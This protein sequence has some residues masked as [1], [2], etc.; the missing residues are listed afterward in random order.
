VVLKALLPKQPAYGR[1][2]LLAL[3]AAEFGFHPAPTPPGPGLVAQGMET[4][5]SV[6]TGSRSN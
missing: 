6:G 3:A 1:A 4:R 2:K 5:S